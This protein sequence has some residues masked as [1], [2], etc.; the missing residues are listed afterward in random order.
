MKKA[1]RQALNAIREEAKM[2]KEEAKVGSIITLITVK[3]Q[4]DYKGRA[5]RVA[6]TP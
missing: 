4:H 5:W 6:V 1:L 3:M 2:S